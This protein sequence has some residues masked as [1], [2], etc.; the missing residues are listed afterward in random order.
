VHACQ[1]KNLPLEPKRTQTPVV[2][3]VWAERRSRNRAPSI[4]ISYVKHAG[5]AVAGAHGSHRDNHSGNFCPRRTQDKA[6]P[7]S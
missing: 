5:T 6:P 3:T 2:L 1:I 7:F 4:F